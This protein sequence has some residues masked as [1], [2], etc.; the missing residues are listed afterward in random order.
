MNTDNND[1]DLDGL[2]DLWKGAMLAQTESES[3]TDNQK[4]LFAMQQKTTAAAKAIQRNLL[5][6]ILVTIPMIV[7]IYIGSCYLP[8]TI[9]PLLWVAFILVTLGYHVYLYWKLK[10]QQPDTETLLVSVEKQV[11]EIRGFM[12]MYQILEIS[13]AAISVI[14]VFLMWHDLTKGSFWLL[15]GY[16][17]IAVLAAIGSFVSV[18]WYANKLYG[19]HYTA[20][21]QTYQTLKSA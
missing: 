12:K 17:M 3:F 11:G 10:N 6:E 18:R 16:I 13:L 1:F 15:P 9:S 21:L 2:K 14:A 19:K 8:Y 7:A 4:I 20:L 5:L